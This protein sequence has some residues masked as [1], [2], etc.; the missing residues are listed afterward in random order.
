MNLVAQPAKRVHDER[1]E[2]DSLLLVGI[3]AALGVVFLTSLDPC[4]SGRMQLG[5]DERH[6]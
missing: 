5:V 6:V 1:D 2:L 4:R 3:V